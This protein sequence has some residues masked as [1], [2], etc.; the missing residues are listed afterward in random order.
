MTSVVLIT[1]A[2][3]GLGSA[4]AR[5]LAAAGNRLILTDLSQD[6]LEILAEDIGEPESLMTA[7]ADVIEPS[8]I[9][10]VVAGAV[11]SWGRLDAVVHTA[12]GDLR[13]WHGVLDYPLDSWQRC[14]DMNL[15][16][17]FNV[18][19]AAGRVMVDQG[20]GGHI[21]LVSSGS[22]LRPTVSNV[23][24][25]ASKAGMIGLMR[26]A[27]LDLAPSGIRV[28]L[29]LPGLTLHSAV[30]L[31]EDEEL[32]L[33]PLDDSYAAAIEKY[34]EN[35]VLGE[36]STPEDFAENVANLLSS[37]VISGQV[38]NFDSKVFF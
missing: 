1:G 36:L 27:A 35:T 28:N 20:G 37:R 5:R 9:E 8:E 33:V 22:A 24:Y 13:E 2:A 16:G 3:G 34:K 25:T 30:H 38:I 11:E 4:L 31:R 6:R 29:I 32:G 18:V 7:A 10:G 14:L 21:A 23:G 26:S 15:T 12:G 17:S 19:R